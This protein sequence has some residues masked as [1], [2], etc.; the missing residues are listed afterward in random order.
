MTFEQTNQT[1]FKHSAF[2][3]TRVVRAFHLSE[4]RT[5][6]WKVEKHYPKSVVYIYKEH[7]E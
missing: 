3:L 4:S 2:K 1:R 7:Y 5:G 6:K